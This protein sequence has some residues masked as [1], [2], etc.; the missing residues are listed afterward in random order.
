MINHE[1]NQVPRQKLPRSS[2]KRSSSVKMAFDHGK[3]IPWYVDE[4]IPGDSFKA[5]MS[6]FTRLATPL[7]PI[8]DNIKLD[9]YGFFCPS[10]ILWDNFEKFQGARDNPSDSI[11]FTLPQ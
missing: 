3:L 7:F 4:I 1:F 10:R 5:Y 11:D 2:F 6:V 9:V 8:M